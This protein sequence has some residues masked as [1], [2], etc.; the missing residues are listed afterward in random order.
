M[1]L[2]IAAILTLFGRPILGLFGAEFVTGSSALAILTCGYLLNA[3]M[4]TSG[5]LLIMTRHERAA[6]A[7]FACSAAINVAGNLLFIPIWGVAGAAAA[8]AL[9][10][11][12]VSIAFAVL[13]YRKL[14]IQPTA[15]FLGRAPN[16]PQSGS[17]T[18]TDGAHGKC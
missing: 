18:I 1:A 5:Y 3:A 16:P 8:T 14:R 11:A 7:G 12:V 9:S 13:A 15:L 10:V 17:P 2:P 6:A 4:G